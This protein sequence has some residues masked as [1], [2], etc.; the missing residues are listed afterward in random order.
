MEVLITGSGLY[1][2]AETISNDELVES[3]NTYVDNYNLENDEAIKSG[4]SKALVHSDSE[5]IKK[6]SGIEQRFVLDKEGILDPARMRPNLKARS[7]EEISVQAEIAVDACKQAMENAGRSAKDIDAVICGC[8][9]LQ[10]AYPAVSIEIQDALNIEGYAYDMN[11]ACSSSTF[12]IQNAYNDI[13]SGVAERI[14]VVNPDICS[15]HLNFKDRDGHFIFGDAC[16]S[17]LLERKEHKPNS[18]AFEI[19]G[20]R[21]K[22]KFS[23]NIRNNFGFL[24]KPE[25]SDSENPDKLFIQNGRKVYKDV[26][27]MVEEHIKAHLEELNLTV[28]EVT[29]LW[30]HQ[31][32]LNMNESISKRILGRD[33]SEKEMPIVLDEYANTSSAGSIIA[34]HK[35]NSDINSGEVGVICSF[36]A[37]YSVGSVV[38]RKL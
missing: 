10:R 5:F 18:K 15:A 36:G 26:V 31:A 14:L 4:Q 16:T 30:L 6:V 12:A 1:T 20:T 22:T 13:Q 34:F 27:P 9:N 35:N 11:V 2:P 38:V 23:N 29:R 3:Y 19:L 37:G 24:N 17:V 21:L 32:N 33:P 28:P 7:N 8:A 25:N